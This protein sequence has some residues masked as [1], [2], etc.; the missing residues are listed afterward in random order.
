[1]ATDTLEM[2]GVKNVFDS[3]AGTERGERMA[4]GHD[5][6]VSYILDQWD[7][8]KVENL[9]DV[10]C[11]NG[12]ALVQAYKR[13]AENLAGLDLSSNMIAEAKKYIPEADLHIGSAESMK[14]WDK[15]SCS[16]IISVEALYYLD[17]PEKGLKE[18]RR[19]LKPGGRIAVAIDYYE[20]NT[21]THSWADALGLKLQLLSEQ[22]WAEMFIKAGFEDIELTRIVRNEHV[23]TQ[24]EFKPSEYFPTYED[25]KKYIAAGALLISN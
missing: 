24:P 18:M 10:G 4:K 6:L 16:H 23:I 21:G 5:V 22:K 15:D 14:H 11:G 3:W 9:L 19:V 1:M 12:R 13:G 7:F 20:E 25:Y 17:K 8:L 2:K